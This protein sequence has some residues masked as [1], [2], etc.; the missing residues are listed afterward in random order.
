MTQWQ[1]AGV[2]TAT[3]WL[4]CTESLG[5]SQQRWL[6]PCLTHHVARLEDAHKAERSHRLHGARGHALNCPRLVFRN[7]PALGAVPG[8]HIHPL[9]VPNIVA[10]EVLRGE[11]ARGKEVRLG[12]GLAMGGGAALID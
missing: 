8:Q 6:Q 12:I 4:P 5:P 1:R 10:N 9:L 11:E 7:S 2:Q 3:W